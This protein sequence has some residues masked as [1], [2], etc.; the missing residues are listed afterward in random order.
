MRS[1]P[2]LQ[3]GSQ[4]SPALRPV[5]AFEGHGVRSRMV[6]L[7]GLLLASTFLTPA[8]SSSAQK[9]APKA[10]FSETDF[11]FGKVM[12]GSVV[13][14]DFV[15][16]NQG[17]AP[18]RVARASMTPPLI[19]TRMPHEIAP[20]AEGVI[21]FK[22]D[23]SKLGGLFQGG[24][25]VFLDDPALPEVDLNFKGQ[26]IPSVELAPIPAFFVSALRGQTKQSSIEIINHGAGPL[27]IESIEH[28]TARFTTELA[29]VER[30]QRYRLTLTLRPDGPGGRSTD[31]IVIRTT[32]KSVPVLEVP[33]NTY[34]HERVYTFPDEVDLGALRIEDVQRNPGLL[35]L[36][37]QTLMIYQEGGSDFQV[38]LKT[39]LPGLDLKWERGP[40][41]D[42]YQITA[43]LIPDK[44][45]VGA[46]K[47]SIFIETNDRQFPTLTIPV[48]GSILGHQ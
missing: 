24:I 13:E 4:G 15:L 21:H 45:K 37:A 25:V 11:D 26:V 8:L 16:K 42:R 5:R 32:S 43:T 36:T 48:S 6:F 46:I 35:Q 40:K 7:A 47:G 12:A 29:T 10:D 27:G 31:A 41:G 22:L 17:S 14:H 2:F 3:I 23:T 9:D 39:D 33:A 20:G 1:K 38:K 19:A 18:L 44:I 28:P 34:L 30:G